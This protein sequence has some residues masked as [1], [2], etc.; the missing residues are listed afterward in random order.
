MLT[1][2]SAKEI[3]H[4]LPIDV[5]FAGFRG[6]TLSL[7]QAGWDL[8]MD[9]RHDRYGEY[10][11]RLAM[12]HSGAKL[13]ALSQMIRL[14]YGRIGAATSSMHEYAQLLASMYFVIEHVAPEF[15]FHVMPVQ[16]VGSFS[17][18]FQAIDP[19][20]QERVER[21]SIRD[22]KFFKVSNPEL[23][24]IIVDPSQVPE[25]LGM[26]LRAQEKTMKEVRSRERSRENTQ[27]VR[28]NMSGTKPAHHV[29]AQIITL[30]S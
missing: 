21:E 19:F 25:L 8:S 12:R 24:D 4:S 15:Q 14:P 10:T 7:A 16:S 11:M 17:R 27:R 1:Q 22:F 28:E 2:N 20:P 18:G 6:N 5:A 9:Q 3:L 29:Q 13:Y 30:A 23:K 26:V